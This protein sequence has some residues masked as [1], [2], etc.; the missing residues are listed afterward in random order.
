MHTEIRFHGDP[1][2]YRERQIIPVRSPQ[3][4]AEM[5]RQLRQLHLDFIRRNWALLERVFSR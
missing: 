4:A 3:H 1:P 5:E 2:N